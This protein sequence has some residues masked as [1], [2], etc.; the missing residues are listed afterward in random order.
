MRAY[1][2]STSD[3]VL[4]TSKAPSSCRTPKLQLTGSRFPDATSRAVK[5]SYCATTVA[6]PSCRTSVEDA[7]L[8]MVESSHLVSSKPSITLA[9]SSEGGFSPAGLE[10]DTIVSCSPERPNSCT[11]PS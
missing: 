8:P 7:P 1:G 4:S 10:A 11:S 3:F 9:E 5:S 2:A 6:T